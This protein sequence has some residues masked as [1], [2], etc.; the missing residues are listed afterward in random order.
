MR[1]ASVRIQN[2]RSFAD[3]T[4]HF[5]DYTC[6]VGPNGSGKS[7]VLTAL[8]VFFKNTGDA[9]TDLT[10]L[11]REDFHC[12]HKTHNLT[13]PVEITVTFDQL[14]PEAQQDL[15]DYFRH[16]QLVV[17][18]RAEWN[19]DDGCAQVVQYG[20]RLGMEAFKPFFRALG[21][22]AL[23]KDLKELY[24]GLRLQFDELPAPGTK[25]A[26]IDALHEY[27]TK[28]PDRC[29]PIPSEDQF[30]GF[31]GGTNRLE[32][33]IQWVFV[34]AVKD[35]SDEQVEANNTLLGTLLERTVRTKVSFKE[36][37]EALRK[38]AGTKY[39]AILDAQQGAL[40]EL[41]TSLT[42]KLETWVHPGVG[43]SLEWLNDA[44]KS[45]RVAEPVA[46]FVAGERNFKGKLARLG[47]GYQRS[48]LLALLEEMAAGDPD[49]GPRLIL[50]CEEPEL[51]QHPPQA[52]HIAAVMQQLTTKNAQV[53]V[54]T[55]SPYF[56]SGRQ[57]PDVR[58]VRMNAA[59]CCSEC[60]SVTLDEIAKTIAD[61]SG[62]TP[63]TSTGTLLKIE[64]ALQPVLNEVFFA[65]VLLLVEGLEDA[66]YITTYMILLDL[67]GE[68]RKYRCH[69][70][71]AGGKSSLSYPI[72]IA[73]HLKIPCFVTFDADGHTVPGAGEP[74]PK[75]HRKMHERDN[76]CVLKLHDVAQPEAFPACTLWL[77]RL[78]QW[79][80]EIGKVVDEE[81][82]NIRVIKDKVR[83]SKKIHDGNL[84]KKVLFIGYTL[85]E[86]WDQGK[87]SASLERLC[88]SIIAFGKSAHVF[89]P[90]PQ[91]E[92]P[93]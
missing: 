88:R 86:A 49:T 58:S 30:Y 42:K 55:H 48:F 61:A 31:S 29:T 39:Q 14:S 67:M 36:P 22:A 19:P 54:C 53:V 68:F 74:D 79:P 81:I 18:A 1:I 51:Y 21:D 57:V 64:Q 13:E 33:Y 69:I 12:K 2:F 87:K 91:P 52:R 62:E 70:V 26:M 83:A 24:V 82:D 23:V 75:G 10:K 65:D 71:P 25:Q 3:E 50:G 34:P 60:R 20:H 38:E 11:D 78:V 89:A 4:V 17:S 76:V 45:I 35:A 16:G 40:A 41:S 47:H 72:A 15:K 43:V 5:N 80:T 93:A 63:S 85:N 90:E 44:N 28:Y 73:K 77:D 92:T 56:V 59:K 84:D 37:L 66:A 7:T 9:R 32:K 27:E 6:L 46:Q 8:N